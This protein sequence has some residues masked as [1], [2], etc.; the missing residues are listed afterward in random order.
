MPTGLLRPLYKDVETLRQ[1]DD[2][3]KTEDTVTR[4]GREG[5]SWRLM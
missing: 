1:E 4:V 5:G 3:P 2:E